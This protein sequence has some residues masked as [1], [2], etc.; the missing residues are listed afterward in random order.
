MKNP[1]LRWIDKTL[2]KNLWVEAFLTLKAIFVTMSLAANFN[3][4]QNS[5]L[6]TKNHIKQKFYQYHKRSCYDVLQCVILS[7]IVMSNTFFSRSNRPL[8]LKHKKPS[9][10]DF[11][12]TFRH[13]RFLEVIPFEISNYLLISNSPIFLLQ[14]WSSSSSIWS[15]TILLILIFE[16]NELNSLKK[17][18]RDLR[19]TFIFYKSAQQG[20]KN[21]AI[22]YL[23]YPLQYIWQ[24]SNEHFTSKTRTS[25]RKHTNCSKAS[26]K[27]P[28]YLFHW[29]V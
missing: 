28:F 2:D 15:R 29:R 11:F 10:K 12:V 19:V 25:V 1:S 20:K 7:C 24:I 16:E 6:S 5:I 8:M 18:T 14:I 17:F 4:T 22:N 13:D 26:Y 21:H 23:Q 3:N 27:Y 9:Q